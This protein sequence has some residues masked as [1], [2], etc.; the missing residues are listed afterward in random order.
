MEQNFGGKERRTDSYVFTKMSQIRD[1]YSE[2]MPTEKLERLITE[3]NAKPFID[4]KEGRAAH[5]L[6]KLKRIEW[7][8][9]R[10]LR[11]FDPQYQE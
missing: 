5:R 4:R 8:L 6:Q 10:Y 3:I 1:F 11:E 7:E 9:N 2:F